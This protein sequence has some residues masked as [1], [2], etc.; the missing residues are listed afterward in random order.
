MKKEKEKSFALQN[1][2]EFYQVL[3]KVVE[4]QKNSKKDNS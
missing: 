4:K 1:L 2:D 3:V